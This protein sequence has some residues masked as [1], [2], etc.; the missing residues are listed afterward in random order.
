M[1]RLD[2]H[3]LLYALDAFLFENPQLFLFLRKMADRLF[4]YDCIIFFVGLTHGELLIAKSIA[5]IR[6]TIFFMPALR[7]LR[8]L[9]EFRKFLL[10]TCSSN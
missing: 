6:T 4:L 9:N 7:S 8:F 2:E 10:K 1:T 3:K 5:L